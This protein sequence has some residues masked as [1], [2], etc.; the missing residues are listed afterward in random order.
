MGIHDGFGNGQAQAKAVAVGTGVV[1][2]VK[3]VKN[4][5]QIFRRDSLS[6]VL[7]DDLD[8]IAVILDADI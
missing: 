8:K 7:D 1:G 4:V 5:R 2:A 3:A 6:V